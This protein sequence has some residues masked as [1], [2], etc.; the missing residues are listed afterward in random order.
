MP[1]YIIA[2]LLYLVFHFYALMMLVLLARTA[3]VFEDQLRKTI[4]DDGNRERYRAR[5]EN[6]LFLQL[7][8][9]MRGE[10]SGFNGLLLGAI[11]V[12]TVVL[13]PIATLILIQMMFLPITASR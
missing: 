12:I 5:V 13:A 7:L 10:R 8:V 3:A 9:G 4:A 1:F 6:A 2:P 11:A